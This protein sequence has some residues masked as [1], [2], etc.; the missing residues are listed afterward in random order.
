MEPGTPEQ[1]TH[2]TRLAGE[3]GPRGFDIE[4]AGRGPQR[5][6][7]VINR[8]DRRLAE[9]VACATAADGSWCFWWPSQQL[10]GPAADLSAVAATIATVLRAVEGAP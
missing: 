3:L 5:S 1:L 8:A 6:L 10:I 4:L 2:L 7:R 9:R